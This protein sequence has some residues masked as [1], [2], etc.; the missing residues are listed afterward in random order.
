MMVDMVVNEIRT[1]AEQ[2]AE[3]LSYEWSKLASG[4]RLPTVRELA[5]RFDVSPTTITRALD[6]LRKDELIVSRQGY[7]IFRA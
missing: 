7:G 1:P 2:V 4:T 5:I 6:M 3:T